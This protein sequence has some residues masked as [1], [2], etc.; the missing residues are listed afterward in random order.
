MVELS[1]VE[2]T[3]PAVIT[4]AP[5]GVIT[6]LNP[7]AERLLDIAADAVIGQLT[8]T[9]FHDP[10]ELAGRMDAGVLQAEALIADRFD[11]IVAVMKLN[12]T[13]VIWLQECIFIHLKQ[14]G[15]KM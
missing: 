3:Q 5:D 15:I 8:P 10:A 7:A 4:T 12:L 9:L 1:G 13:E 11:A 6:S 14:M 2:D